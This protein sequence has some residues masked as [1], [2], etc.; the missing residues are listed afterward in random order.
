MEW[1][2]LFADLEA[3]WEAQERRELDAEVADRTRRERALVDLTA[4]LA[5]HRGG[6]VTVRT[7]AGDPVTGSVVDVGDGWLAVTR[8]QRSVL[9]SLAAVV[10]IDG[11]TTRSL[12]ATAARRFGLG[13]ALR[14]LSRDRATVTVLDVSGGLTTGTIDAVGA[15]HLQVALHHSDQP[16]RAPN[17]QDARAIPFLALVSVSTG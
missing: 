10:G 4:R 7:R 16:R 2:G 1:E 3:Q 11:L 9:L 15:D 6:Q 13:Y 5:A 14:G 12:D 8:P 17:V